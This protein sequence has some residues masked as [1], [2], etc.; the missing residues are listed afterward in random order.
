MS[1]HRR[2]RSYRQRP[3]KRRASCLA[4]PVLLGVA[5]LLLIEAYAVWLRPEVSQRIG[6][7]IGSGLG[8][9]AVPGGAVL[10][11]WGQPDAQGPAGGALQEQMQMAQQ[12]LPTAI[13]AMPSGEVRLTQQEANAFLAA[14]RA[15]LQPVDNL[16]LQFVP[17]QVRSTVDIYGTTL[18]VVSGVAVQDGRLAVVEPQ[19]EGVPGYVLSIE[20]LIRPLEAQ[21]NQQLL[22]QGRSLRGVRVEQGQM[23]V[24]VE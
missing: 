3:K 20:E 7:H 9:P 11:Q 5:L 1:R 15:A 10:P 2:A 14:N 18:N 19:I 17:C 8:M 13:A 21:F 23:V 24:F 16:T 4:W 6:Q 22:A 12:S